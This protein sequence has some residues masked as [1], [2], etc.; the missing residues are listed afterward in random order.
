MAAKVVGQVKPPGTEPRFQALTDAIEIR[1]L[2][3]QASTAQSPVDIQ[4]S[5]LA[6][7]FRGQ[8]LD[9]SS[10]N[11]IQLLIKENEEE[12]PNAKSDSPPAPIV[13]SELPKLEALLKSQASPVECMLVIYLK[14]L[15]LLGVR[16][17]QVKLDQFKLS[18]EPPFRFFKIQR[19]K[20]SRLEIPSGYDF[21]L[22]IDA[23]EGARR[24]VQKRLLD[25]SSSGLGFQVVS[26]REAALFRVG[27]K[28]RAA[29]LEIQ[30]RRFCVDLEVKNLIPIPLDRK[31]SG[32]K[33]GCSIVQVITGDP[34]FL[35]SYVTANIASWR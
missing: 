11:H 16:G 10:A 27:S 34:E 3:D 13:A 25:I 35:A 2:F 9:P 23:I 7:K 4:F 21:F 15:L 30:N 12:D 18:L 31:W 26:P 19:R 6:L 1:R 28:I 5:S 24:K 33:V 20:E 14:G 22:T 8:L 29:S 17:T 32:T